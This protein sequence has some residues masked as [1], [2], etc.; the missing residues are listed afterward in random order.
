M[1]EPT[2]RDKQ[3]KFLVIDDFE[4]VLDG[5]VHS[6]QQHFPE[7]EI[8][9]ARTVQEA[10][11]RLA[12]QPDLVVMDL[13][14]PETAGDEPRSDVGVQLLREI[15]QT[16]PTLHIVVQSAYPKALVRLKPAITSH[17]GGFTI[18]EKSISLKEMIKR[19]EWA[20]DGIVYTPKEMRTR[21]EIKPEWL[22]L[23]KLAFEKGLTDQAI[24]QEMRVSERTVRNYWTQIQ[25]AL[26]VYPDPGKNLRVQTQVRA[27]EE[28]LID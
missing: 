2:V 25:D 28:G 13:A 22:Q 5:T 26:G 15:L 14:I 19:V 27:R 3:Q 7:V 8:V 17:D 6:L 16:N 18:A 4:T 11:E 1:G 9:T 21:L 10:Q 20:L 12:S 24:A 23:L